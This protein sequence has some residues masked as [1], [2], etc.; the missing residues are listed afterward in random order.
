[1]NNDDLN[2]L[3]FPDD[4]PKR[5]KPSPEGRSNNR[6]DESNTSNADASFRYDATTAMQFFLRRQRDKILELLQDSSPDFTRIQDLYLSHVVGQFHIIDPGEWSCFWSL[7]DGL[8]A[9]GVSSRKGSILL[10][11]WKEEDAPFAPPKS[12][13][14]NVTVFSSLPMEFHGNLVKLQT[15]NEAVRLQR[16]HRAAHFQHE[17]DSLKKQFDDWATQNH[18]IF[19]PPVI[20]ND[21]L[22]KMPQP[23]MTMQEI[24][25]FVRGGHFDDLQGK[26]EGGILQLA[27]FKAIHFLPGDTPQGWEDFH[28]F[29]S[30]YS[31]FAQPDPANPDEFRLNRLDPRKLRYYF[32]I[33]LPSV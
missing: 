30:V 17:R 29:C 6:P 3:L 24:D 18:L 28:W 15:Y 27:R 23:L 22:K 11:G 14:D 13:S 10:G 20:I 16:L 1:M 12:L 4:D 33:Q 7:I 26:A 9:L 8:F 2:N 21:S 5:P 19:R 25:A 32:L 31:L